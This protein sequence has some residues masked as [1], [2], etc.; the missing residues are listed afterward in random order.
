VGFSISRTEEMMGRGDISYLRVSN[1]KR[2]TDNEI[3]KGE[4]K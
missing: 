3:V 4:E 2:S 1:A